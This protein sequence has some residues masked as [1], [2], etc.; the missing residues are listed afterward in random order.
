MKTEQRE[1]GY[2]MKLKQQVPS[3]ELCK[4]LEELGWDKETLFAWY[5]N[6]HVKEGYK[7]HYLRRDK[8][9][10]KETDLNLKI[11]PAPT[12]AELGEELNKYGFF[13]YGATHITAHGIEPCFD[14]DTEAN[15]RSA[16]WIYLRENKLI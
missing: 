12:V 7:I 4:K 14:E 10:L 1:R 2:K 13:Q 11:A 15:S 8:Y 3:L 5:E 6:P 9:T 16:L